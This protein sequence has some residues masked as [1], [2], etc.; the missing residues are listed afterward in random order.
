[1]SK[2]VF[3]DANIIL[4]IFDKNRPSYSDSLRFYDFVV[5][6][7]YKLFTSCDIITTIYYVNSKNG[8]KET[9]DKIQQINKILKVIEFSNQEIDD[10]C[11]LMKTDS[12]YSDLEDTIQYVLAKKLNCEMIVSNDKTFY[13]SD[14]RVISSENFCN[15]YIK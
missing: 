4:D 6:N 7:G 2:R 15:E 9:L 5:S 3:I 11:E 14:M 13:A 10:T 12:S 8:K 1:M